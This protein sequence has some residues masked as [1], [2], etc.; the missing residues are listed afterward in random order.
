MSTPAPIS[1]R[2]H[3]HR[4]A[5]ELAQ[6]DLS[7]LELVPWE[8]QRL[9][10]LRPDRFEALTRKLAEIVDRACELAGR[11]VSAAR[12]ELAMAKTVWNFT[13]TLRPDLEAFGDY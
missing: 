13:K 9:N 12:I 11:H 5:V 1:P 2:E 10:R 8:D 7:L 6:L 3:W 4:R